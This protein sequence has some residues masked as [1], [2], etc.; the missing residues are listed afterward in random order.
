VLNGSHEIIGWRDLRDLLKSDPKSI[1]LVDVRTP[2]EFS[3]H[4]LPGAR[5]IELDHL[6]SVTRVR[7]IELFR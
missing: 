5:N 2:E 7:F 4:T 6:R 1:Q 3:I